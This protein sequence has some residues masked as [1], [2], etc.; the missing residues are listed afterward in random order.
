MKQYKSSCSDMCKMT[1]MFYLCVLVANY[2][3]RFHVGFFSEKKSANK[4]TVLSIGQI[5]C[6][7]LASWSSLSLLIH[8]SYVT[9]L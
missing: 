5:L 4:N 2:I 3:K 7:K 8:L 9:Y 6:Q 1:G